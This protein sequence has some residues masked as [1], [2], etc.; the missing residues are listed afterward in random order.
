LASHQARDWHWGHH[1][2]HTEN[3]TAGLITTQRSKRTYKDSLF[4]VRTN[5]PSS[6][7]SMRSY[8]DEGGLCEPVDGTASWRVCSAGHPILPRKASANGH[9]SMFLARFL[10]TCGPADSPHGPETSVQLRRSGNDDRNP[11]PR[12]RGF[13]KGQRFVIKQRRCIT[14]ADQKP[15][16]LAN[17]PKTNTLQQV[18]NTKRAF[19]RFCTDVCSRACVSA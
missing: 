12:T 16:P 17:E 15:R 4:P 18:S 5:K 19:T 14:T 6:S 9:P 13:I 11:A 1:G 2:V 10:G 7:K 3:S 8:K